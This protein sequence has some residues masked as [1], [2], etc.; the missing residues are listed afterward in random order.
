MRHDQLFSI[1]DLGTIVSFGFFLLLFKNRK[2]GWSVLIQVWWCERVCVAENCKEM[3]LRITS[4]FDS[5][6]LSSLSFSSTPTRNKGKQLRNFCT[7]THLFYLTIQFYFIF[8][9]KQFIKCWCSG[10]IVTFALSLQSA[11]SYTIKLEP[12]STDLDEFVL[13]TDLHNSFSKSANTTQTVH[14]N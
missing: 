8:H 12:F 6:H 13:L 3:L 2:R 1:L 4:H 9:G 10:A 11:A 14:A 5:V 7:F